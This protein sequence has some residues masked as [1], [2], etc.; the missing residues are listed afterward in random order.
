[1]EQQIVALIRTNKITEVNLIFPLRQD[2]QID[3][4]TLTDAFKYNHSV[5][6]LYLKYM[7][8][9]DLGIQ[10][11]SHLL[12]YNKTLV[13]LNLYGNRYSIEG[14]QALCEA[15]EVNQT[16]NTLGVQSSKINNQGMRLLCLS[17]RANRTLTCLDLMYNEIDN[18]GGQAI[19]ELLKI[20]HTITRMFFYGNRLDDAHEQA[21]NTALQNNRNWIK[22]T[23]NQTLF[24]LII[25]QRHSYSKNPTLPCEVWE[26]II[27]ALELDFPSKIKGYRSC[28]AIKNFITQR[29]IFDEF[30]ARLAS[31][32]S[33]RLIEKHSKIL[34]E[35]TFSF[36]TSFKRQL[37]SG[38]EYPAT[39]QPLQKKFKYK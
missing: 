37:E 24:I 36:L 31:K 21:I 14:L 20:N 26:L 2:Q 33:F 15:L 16:L 34:S 8:I 13:S 18:E 3:V 17:L 5:T 7:N 4:I 25:L 22:N 38:N 6:S 28:S 11:F 39:G 19:G 23:R 30:Q 35:T 1:M 32:K 29:N 27:N 9:D 10:I 12:K